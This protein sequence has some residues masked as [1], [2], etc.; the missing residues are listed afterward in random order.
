MTATDTD[1]KE[2]VVVISRTFDA[3]REL[4]FKMF[5]DPK[6]LTQFWG[7]KGFTA[8]SCELDLRVG[9]AFRLEMRGPDGTEYPCTAIYREIVKPE[10]IVY[11]GPPED[12]PGCGGG[13]PPRAVVTMTFTEHGGRTTITIHTHLQ[14]MADREAAVQMGFKEGWAASLDRLADHLAKAGLD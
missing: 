4:V 11:A 5:T 2:A 10:R 1:V 14:S 6:H 8:P 3:P 13:L 7:P 9:G 12:S